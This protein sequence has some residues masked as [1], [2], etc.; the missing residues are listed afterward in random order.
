MKAEGREGKQ[1]HVVMLPLPIPGHINPMVHLSF[2]LASMGVKVTFVNSEFNKSKI[3]LPS[4]EDNEEEKDKLYH[5]INFL[6]I[7]DG[8]PAE[9]GRTSDLLGLLMAVDASYGRR[10]E[11]LLCNNIALQDPPIT[12]IVGNT[13]ISHVQEAAHRLGV[14]YASFWTQSAASYASVLMVAKGYRPPEDSKPSDVLPARMLPGVPATL[15][16]GELNAFLQ[17]YNQEDFMFRLF[18]APHD[19]I[20]EADY[21]L[22]NTFEELEEETLEALRQELPKV[23]AV[24]PLLPDS[25]LDEV[26]DMG[27]EAG[28][29]G[30][31]AMWAAEE[32]CLEWLDNQEKESV[33]YVAFGSMGVLSKEQI[34]E[35][36]MGLE[37]SK[38]AFLWVIRVEQEKESERVLPE[39]FLKRTEGRGLVISW[40]PQLRVLRHQAVGAF[41]THCGWNSTIEG[42]SAGMPLLVWPSCFSDQATNGRCAVDGWRLGL[43]L[44][45]SAAPPGLVERGELQKKVALLMQK[46]PR[47]NELRA[48][49]SQWRALAVQAHGSSSIGLQRFLCSF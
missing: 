10:F 13:F 24:G 41:L 29:A 46:G 20:A 34:E 6:Y 33:I 49:A 7:T 39:G 45:R 22:M 5:N 31:A 14:P 19:R 25:F 35:I 8:L 1:K 23:L 11:E 30:A 12:C 27:P 4:S 38:Q 18:V 40:A 16:L 26:D 2:K 43:S 48:Q 21:I 9:H 37:A 44:E 15:K 3:R 42:I 47:G 28:G 17:S 32:G 36:A